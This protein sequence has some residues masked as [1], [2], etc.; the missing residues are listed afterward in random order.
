MPQGA[1]N[2]KKYTY[3][4][5]SAVILVFGIFTV[6]EVTKRFHDDTVVDKGRMLTAQTEQLGYILS[7]GQK[8]NLKF[9]ISKIVNLFFTI[10]QQ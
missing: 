7:N 3:V 9:M 10:S 4:W 2:K 6:V 1:S 8:R 5:V